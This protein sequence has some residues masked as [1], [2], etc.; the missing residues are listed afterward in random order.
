MGANEGDICT[1]KTSELTK[2]RDKV[3]RE[4]RIKMERF[5]RDQ[6]PRKA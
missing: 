3:D 1:G 4:S 2:N 6:Y 5:R